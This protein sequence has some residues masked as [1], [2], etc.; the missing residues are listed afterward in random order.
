MSRLLGYFLRGLVFVVPIALTLYVGW[1]IFHAIDSWL[2]LPV[3]GVGFVLTI[4]LITLVGFLASGVITR[5][6][7]GAVE[8]VFTRLPF[9]RLLYSSTK[10]LLEAF[11]GEKRRFDRPVLVALVPGGSTKIVGFV[12]RSSLE[13]LGLADHVA[14][15]LPQSYNFAGNVLVVPATQVEP[16]VAESSDVMAFVVSG[17]VTGM[18]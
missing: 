10:D 7:L 4:L 15:Y 13:Q 17:G 14:V 16:L 9:V 5:T 8:R 1:W 6:L 12:T 3:P 2:G 18:A 11:V